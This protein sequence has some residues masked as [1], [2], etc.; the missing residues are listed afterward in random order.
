MEVG[1]EASH[2]PLL[3]NCLMVEIGSVK[4]GM[5]AV[6][7]EVMRKMGEL[8]GMQ[9]TSQLDPLDFV[10]G[11]YALASPDD[12]WDLTK[13]LFK[14]FEG[15]NLPQ[16][17]AFTCLDGS[18]FGNLWWR[19]GVSRT[20]HLAKNKEV[21]YRVHKNRS[22][23]WALPVISVWPPPLMLGPGVADNTI[24]GFELKDP[25]SEHTTLRALAKLLESHYDGYF[26]AKVCDGGLTC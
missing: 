14:S 4:A 20:G 2:P 26:F 12:E 17:E 13:Q 6:D 9:I 3:E 23:I 16:G 5:C 21:A 22:F 8:L 10:V 11:R 25:S 1:D 18:S 19:S 15:G 24:W 7:P